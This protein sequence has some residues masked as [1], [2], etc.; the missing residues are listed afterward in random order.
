MLK[1]EFRALDFLFSSCGGN[2]LHL[3]CKRKGAESED[4]TP[5]VLASDLGRLERDGLVVL[6]ARGF[7]RIGRVL[8][9]LTPVSDPGFDFTP[10]T[11]EQ[12]R[13]GK[14]ERN[15]ATGSYFSSHSETS[16]C[17]SAL[18]S[19]THSPASISESGSG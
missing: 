1:A 15:N 4:P 6:P 16:M 3:S 12:E 17:C 14:A 19:M 18:V 5:R 7:Q 2:E 8:A 13:R 9:R 11:R 10:G